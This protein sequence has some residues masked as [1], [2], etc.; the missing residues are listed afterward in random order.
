ML[1]HVITED[2]MV[3]ILRRRWTSIISRRN[4]HRVR[5]LRTRVKGLSVVEKDITKK[6]STTRF[7][8]PMKGPGTAS[9]P[10]LLFLVL[11]LYLKVAQLLL[12]PVKIYSKLEL[13][14]TTTLLPGAREYCFLSLP[15]TVFQ[16]LWKLHCC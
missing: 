6:K 9:L 11:S 16:K 15:I 8:L 5:C 2:L 14:S 4:S 7:L 3:A 13:R 10:Y 1:E 12:S